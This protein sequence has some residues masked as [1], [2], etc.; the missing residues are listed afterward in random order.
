MTAVATRKRPA[1]TAKGDHP[2]SHRIN[3]P[4]IPQVKAAH[5]AA[6]KPWLSSLDKVIELSLL[7]S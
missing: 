5:S 7:P 1:K 4:A 6:I 3:M 2:G